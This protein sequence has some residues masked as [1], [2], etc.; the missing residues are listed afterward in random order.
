MCPRV[1]CLIF[2]Q[3]LLKKIGIYQQNFVK[4]PNINFYKTLS[5]WILAVL[6]GQMDRRAD[7]HSEAG[8]RIFQTA[9]R[10]LHNSELFPQAL[11][12][13][14]GIRTEELI[15]SSNSIK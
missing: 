10:T 2:G 4:I 7:K 3:V 9:A 14:F 15:V 11:F 12:K 6:C 5:V 8:S 13:C 1:K